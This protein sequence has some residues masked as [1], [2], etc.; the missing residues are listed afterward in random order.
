[1]DILI[2]FVI[3]LI[4]CLAVAPFFLLNGEFRGK[5]KGKDGGTGL[6]TPVPGTGDG[7]VFPKKATDSESDSDVDGDGGGDGGAD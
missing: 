2:T 1:M 6:V 4:I 5:S 3:I 7:A